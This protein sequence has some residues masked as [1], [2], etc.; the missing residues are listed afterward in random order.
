MYC[1]LTLIILSGQSYGSKYSF[2]IW[3]IHYTKS[4]GFKYIKWLNISIG[5]IYRALTASTHLRRS[6]PES[7]SNRVVHITQRF[8]TGALPSDGL[9]SYPEHSWWGSYSFVE[10]LSAYS[11]APAHW[12]DIYILYYFVGQ[13]VWYLSLYWPYFYF[14]VDI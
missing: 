5:P 6:R 3:I 1:N 7:N 13:I 14:V 11:V 8:W 2:V 4:N 12:A 10:M 9:L